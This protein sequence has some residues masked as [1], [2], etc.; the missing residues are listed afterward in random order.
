LQLFVRKTGK[1]DARDYMMFP[2]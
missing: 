1:K 2:T